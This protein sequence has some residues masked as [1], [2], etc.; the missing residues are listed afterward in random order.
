MMNNKW[1]VPSLFIILLAVIVYFSLPFFQGQSG[2]I[3][4]VSPYKNIDWQTIRQ[5]KAQL[6]THTT[7]SDGSLSPQAVVDLYK[8]GG[9]DILAITDHWRVTYPWEEFSSFEPSAPVVKRFEDGA[10]DYSSREELFRYENRDPG[11]LGM[12][13]IQASEPS[14]TGERS[15]HMVS[16][17]SDVTGQD[18]EFESTLAAIGEAGGLVS[19]AHPA[20]STEKKNNTAE[21]YIFYFDKYPQIYGIDIF[22]RATF[23]DPGRWPYSL[24]LYSGLIRHYGLPGQEGWR[25]V[26]MTCTDDLH[27]LD[28]FDQGMQLQLVQE[29]TRDQV[30]KSLKE[31]AFFWVAKAV[32]AEVPSITSI[33]FGK[34][35][36]TVKGRGFDQVSWYYEGKVIHTGDTFDFF[37]NGTDGQF[38]VHFMA[39]TSDFSVEGKSGALLGS[40]PFWIVK[41][42]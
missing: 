11:T 31:G 34:S 39:H 40:Q 42:K 20:R 6:H 15:H 4:W 28:D 12:L 10:T 13:A 7:R 37:R 25:P 23:N 9:Y 33:D 32:D 2:K 36:I 41:K 24:E 22:T 18:M 1:I 19:F 38:Y 26:W 17:F 35:S 16:L 21:D 30:Y 14:F 3:E 8:Q 27:N 5:A 29:I